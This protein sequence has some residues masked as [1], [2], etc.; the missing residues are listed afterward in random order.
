[1][2]AVTVWEYFSHQGAT[3]SLSPKHYKSV[4]LTNQISITAALFSVPL[5]VLYYAL[6]LTPLFISQYLT[7]VIL[8]SCVWLN[9]LGR[10]RWAFYQIAKAVLFLVINVNIFFTSSS[11][12][13]ESGFHLLYYAALLGMMLFY[14]LHKRLIFL[15]ARG[16]VPQTGN[17]WCFRAAQCT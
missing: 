16:C 2:N 3:A 13:Y 11:L 10:Q 8:M 6:S 9:H 1:M 17:N 14:N 4:I 15:V 7:F 12:G 5:A